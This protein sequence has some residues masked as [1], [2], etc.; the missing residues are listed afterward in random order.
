MVKI[1]EKKMNLKKDFD[2]GLGTVYERFLLN[3]IFDRLTKQFEIKKILE[4]PIYGMTGVDGINSV[5]LA[6]K[7]VNVTLV[8]FD[9]DRMEKVKNY[10]KVLKLENKLKTFMWNLFL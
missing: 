3:Y 10:W 9:K 2:E 8:D 6:Q 1:K 5:H 4:Y 7:G